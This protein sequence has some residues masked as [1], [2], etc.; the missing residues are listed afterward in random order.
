MAVSNCVR[1]FRGNNRSECSVRSNQRWANLLWKTKSMLSSRWKRKK[2]KVKSF[3]LKRDGEKF[4][5]RSNLYINCFWTF[6]WRSLFD[7]RCSAAGD[8]GATSYF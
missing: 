5:C 3:T 6:L 1:L 4:A 2:S 7:C 8:C